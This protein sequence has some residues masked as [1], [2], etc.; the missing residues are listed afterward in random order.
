[1]SW[2]ANGESA[3]TPPA[4]ARGTRRSPA[5]LLVAGLLVALAVLVGVG[6]Y[7]AAEI[8]RLRDEHTAATER[9]RKDAL[10]LLRISN[11]LASLASLT[12]DMVDRVEPYPM[13]GWQPA[14][15]RVQRDLTEA[16][17]AERAL[18]PA[19][20]EP[21]QQA[22]LES[23][24]SGYG[25]ILDRLFALARA[26]N[27][28][29]AAAVARGD[30]T[31]QHR[32]LSGLVSQFLIVN[33]RMQ[34]EATEANRVIFDRV[35]REILVLVSVLLVLMAVSGVWVISSNRKAFEEVR[36]LSA[37][38][39]ALSWRTLD[40]QEQI[41][42]SISR[43][44]HDDFGQVLTA[45]GTLLGRARRQLKGDESLIR[46]LD[47]VRD[48]AQQALDRIRARSRW[49]HPGV[50]DDFGLEKAVA[51]SVEQ[52]ADQTGINARFSASGPVDTIRDDYAIHVYRIV[53]E[54]LANI[55]R[56]SGSRDATVRLTCTDDWLD[57]EIGD[58]GRGLPGEAAR[59]SEQRGM[60]LVSMR[61]RAELMGGH[62]TLQP[63]S[64]GGLVVHLRVP[65]WSAPP[66]EKVVT[67]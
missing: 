20:R 43:E 51:R 9:N 52:F 59:D 6:A 44:L 42:R 38:L 1:M 37:Q 40:L 3:T 13:S 2:G 5:R 17:A 55:G 19:V 24:V 22:R 29:E 60:G 53:Q 31:R 32:E 56:H 28:S 66:S 54:A 27:E 16:L 33:N 11:D 39:R 61:E 41:Q 47:A 14:F 10:Q 65:A 62:L 15:D 49:L 46:D 35:R 50:L 64:D 48:V 12:R 8:T 67:S 26:G 57:L 4:D 63:A 21:A 36:H 45:V 58:H 25:R 34:Q 7:M 18:A 23:A 30:L